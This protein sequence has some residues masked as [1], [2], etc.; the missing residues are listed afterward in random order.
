MQKS[1]QQN[2]QMSHPSD[3]SCHTPKVNVLM[4]VF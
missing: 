1:E 4:S 3:F 2:V